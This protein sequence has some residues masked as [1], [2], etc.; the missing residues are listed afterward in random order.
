[1]EIARLLDLLLL[2][3]SKDNFTKQMIELVDAVHFSV[4]CLL[5]CRA[6]GLPSFNN[7]L[8]YFPFYYNHLYDTTSTS[9]VSATT[10]LQYLNRTYLIRQHHIACLTARSPGVARW[11]IKPKE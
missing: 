9:T 6:L 10:A 11:S 7:L 1:M 8:L 2:V 5:V 3:L 4:Y